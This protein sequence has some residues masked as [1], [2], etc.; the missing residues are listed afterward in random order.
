MYH[1]PQAGIHSF[2]LQKIDNYSIQ[3]KQ[4]K[5]IGNHFLRKS[6]LEILTLFLKKTTSFLGLVETPVSFNSSKSKKMFVKKNKH[7]N[8]SRESKYLVHR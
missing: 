8:V 7:R 4:L 6:Y 5:L 1:I 2:T 3:N